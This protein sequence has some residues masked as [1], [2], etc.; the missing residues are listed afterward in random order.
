MT[1]TN[2]VK[3]L[4]FISNSYPGKFKYPLDSREETKFFTETWYSFLQDY[5]YQLV[6][7]A[8]KKLIVNKPTWPPAVGELVHEIESLITPAKDKISGGEAWQ[9]ALEAVRKYGYYQAGQAMDS[10]PQM[11]QKA[12]QCYGGFDAVCHSEIH[13][14]FARQ[15]FIKIYQE[16]V[17]KKRR[18]ELLPPSLRKE[19]K[20][21][22]DRFKKGAEV[23]DTDLLKGGEDNQE[24]EMS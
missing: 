7:T 14:S 1:R 6:R 4:T 20:A 21:I 9:L 22:T 2:L 12:V 16:L 13:S 3:V 18:A 23:T 8:V 24:Q 17:N 10:L 19:T 5:D 11:V 15:N